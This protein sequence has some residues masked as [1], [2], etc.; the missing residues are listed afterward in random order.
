MISVVKLLAVLLF[1]FQTMSAHAG[2]FFP[3]EY[4]QFPF[5]EGDLLASRNSTGKF[6]VNKIL[7][8]DRITV[9]RGEFIIIQGKKFTAPVDD[10][11][12]IVSA[13]YGASEFG[14]LEEARAAAS[15]GRWSVQLGHA[16]NRPPG[17]AEGQT[18]VG[19]APVTEAELTGYRAW[20]RAFDRGE[21]GVF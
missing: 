17:A 16:P 1:L 13:S 18:H 19:S 14:S 9:K 21:A 8:V 11:L 15:A 6:S 10:Y 5:K 4:K 3:P 12:L 20:R 7:K 2:D